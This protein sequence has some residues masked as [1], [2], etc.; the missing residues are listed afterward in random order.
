[1]A[2]LFF[3]IDG[4]IWD[5]KNVI[6]ESTKAALKLLKENGHQVFINSGRT[7]VF[8][9]DPR[10]LALDFDGI[11]AGCGT[12]V[13]YR[14]EEL[15]YKTI[16]RDLL[17]DS[18]KLFYDYDMPAMLES[19][20][21]LFMDEDMIGRDDYGKYIIETMQDVIRPIRENE[22]NWT[23]SKYTVLIDGTNWRE[24]VDALKVD[25]EVMVHGEYVMEAAPKGYSKATAI[26]FLCDTLG[27]DRSDTYAFGDGA[28]DL[29]MIGYAGSGI[30]MGNAADEVKM[31]ADYVTDDIHEDGI[32]NACK[33]FGLI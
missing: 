13:D 26:G 2:L 7:K 16:D 27:V 17:V 10:L 29:D 1:M 9:R 4:T 18:V 30:A 3:D 11:C 12:W 15:L 6:P 24:V 28:N 19:R 23:A 31:L 8:L 14:G 33:H 25:F 21:I 32:Y 5:F 22:A 20:D